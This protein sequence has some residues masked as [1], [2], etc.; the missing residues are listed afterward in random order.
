MKNRRKP[1]S[2]PKQTQM[3]HTSRKVELGPDNRRNAASD[4]MLDAEGFE[5]LWPE[6][7]IDTICIGCDVILPVNDLGLCSDCNMKP[8]RD[9]I[10]DRDWERSETA[11][12]TPVSERE[13]LR[14]EAISRYGAA[15][16]LIEPPRK[17]QQRRKPQ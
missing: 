3:G 12:L 8:D 5:E 17:R 15:Y 1:K 14:R 11:A 7:P 10:R 6:E 2:R 9:M 16:E 4:D 13:E